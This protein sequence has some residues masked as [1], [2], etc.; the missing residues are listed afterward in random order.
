MS[1]GLLKSGL[2]VPAMSGARTLISTDTNY[3]VLPTDFF[4][5]M[6]GPTQG[7]NSI[8][9][10][11]P[12]VVGQVV[13]VSTTTNAYTQLDAGTGGVIYAFL[14]GVPTPTQKLRLWEGQIALLWSV[15]SNYWFLLST[16]A[17]AWIPWIPTITVGDGTSTV[18]VGTV[19]HNKMQVINPGRMT[20]A[21]AGQITMGGPA[22]S[23]SL[24]FSLPVP[25]AGWLGA[26]WPGPI[27]MSGVSGSPQIGA[28]GSFAGFSLTSG[29][30]IPPGTM[31][32]SFEITYAIDTQ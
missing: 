11:N 7:S 10:P 28:K 4:V 1:Y 12:S 21:W 24:N 3:Q 13:Y 29:G 22:N 14:T 2:L 16:T 30:A 25:V 8:L 6:N 17:S 26:A 9:L 23:A 15:V 19:Y 31:T 32:L 18:A 20:I 27:V 5:Q